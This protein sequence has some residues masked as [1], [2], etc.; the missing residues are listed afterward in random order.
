MGKPNF[1]GEFEIIVLASLVRLGDDAYG[2]SIIDDI[3][4]RAD[5]SV[6]IGALYSTLSRLE[7]KGYTRAQMGE[8]TPQRGG[9]AKKYYAITAEGQAQLER[10]ARI[11]S[12]MLGDLPH[13]PDGVPAP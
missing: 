12:R 6:S 5:R 11:L 13:W 9:R 2:V 4:S 8:A 10:S 7:K 3:E 1:L